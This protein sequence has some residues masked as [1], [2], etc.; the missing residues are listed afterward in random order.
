MKKQLFNEIKRMQQLADITE[1]KV[2][3]PATEKEKEK[4]WSIDLQACIIE[5]N[6]LNNYGEYHHETNT[7]EVELGSDAMADYFTNAC[8]S[9]KWMKNDKLRGALSF[10]W[11]QNLRKTVHRVHGPD[12]EIE[13]F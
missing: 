3:N 4:Q 12:T 1:I 2:I 9:N 6:E 8:G 7:F 5:D 10:R 11:K 13:F